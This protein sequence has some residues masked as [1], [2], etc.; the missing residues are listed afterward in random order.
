MSLHAVQCRRHVLLHV[1]RTLRRG[2]ARE[3]WHT[4]HRIDWWLSRWTRL[5]PTRTEA[6]LA[7]DGVLHLPRTLLSDATCT[8]HGLRD[9][10]LGAGARYLGGDLRL[11]GLLELSNRHASMALGDLSF[12]EATLDACTNAVLRHHALLADGI[13]VVLA[14]LTTVVV[15]GK[16]AGTHASVGFR[17]RAEVLDVLPVEDPL[18]DY[19]VLLQLFDNQSETFG[20]GRRALLR[21]SDDLDPVLVNDENLL[22]DLPRA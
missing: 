11:L 15:A 17:A 12:S 13:L 18:T 21:L 16:I 8:R 10:I 20:A 22:H 6:W 7:L 2:H 5:S 19:G 9:R 3:V 4:P 1:P 14:T